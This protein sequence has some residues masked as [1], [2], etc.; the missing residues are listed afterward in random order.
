VCGDGIASEVEEC[1]GTDLHGR[2]CEDF[3]FRSGDLACYEDC[4]YDF[5]DC[6][7]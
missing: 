7:R 5:R 3:G 1:D 4:R 2:D 6:R